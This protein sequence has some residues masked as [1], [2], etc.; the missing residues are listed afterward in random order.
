MGL[1]VALTG[2]VCESVWSAWLFAYWPVLS[3]FVPAYGSYLCLLSVYGCISVCGY[4]CISVTM[5]LSVSMS[6]QALRLSVPFAAFRCLCKCKPVG[7]PVSICSCLR[8]SVS[9]QSLS[10]DL[11]VSVSVLIGLACGLL[12]AKCIL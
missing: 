6:V 5:G 7:H 3:V 9:L 10:V 8:V 12:P 11:L 1:I 2:F 4:G